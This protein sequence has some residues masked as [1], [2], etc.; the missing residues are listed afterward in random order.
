MLKNQFWSVVICILTL[1]MLAANILVCVCVWEGG[2][3][4]IFGPLCVIWVPITHGL[5]SADMSWWSERG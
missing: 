5:N 2:E 1:C 4:A 3:G